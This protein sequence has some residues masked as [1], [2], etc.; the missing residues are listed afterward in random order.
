[1]FKL[2]GS[3]R[4]KY[5]SVTPNSTKYH[6]HCFQKL[7]LERQVLLMTVRVN[8]ELEVDSFEDMHLIYGCKK[9]MSQ[10]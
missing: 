3:V 5:K 2:K 1:M 8:K 10:C 4:I 7:Q 9:I 6:H